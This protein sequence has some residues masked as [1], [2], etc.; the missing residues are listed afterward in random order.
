MNA[1]HFHV[2]VL[3]SLFSQG[4]DGALR[5]HE[6]TGLGSEDVER[7]AHTIQRRVLRHFVR[8]GL[9]DDG[10]AIDMLTWQ[11]AGGFSLNASVRVEGWDRAGRER[12]L[13]YCARPPFAL[14]RLDTE[15]APSP[16]TAH[17][18]APLHCVRYRLPRPTPDGRTVRVL[19]P[20]EFLAAI[21]RLIPPPHVHRQRNHGVLAPNAR[22]RPAVTA[23]PRQATRLAEMESDHP[24][25]LNTQADEAA[26]PAAAVSRSVAHHGQRLSSTSPTTPARPESS[27]SARPTTPSLW[28]RLL[29]R[30]YEVFPL[31]CPTCGGEL[32]ILAFL[33]E[34][35]P[36]HDILNHLGLPTRLPR[37]SPARGPPELKFDFDQT[38][39]F[40]PSEPEPSA[41]FHF[42]QSR[43]R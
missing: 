35:Q 40:D 12:L 3:D 43:A 8:R 28:A 29:A 16:A 41:E 17:E 6:A 11:A 39:A 36:I 37:P 15:F 38:P 27:A 2:V 13:R 26:S 31:L 32:R 42:D 14:E 30:I 33:T 5:F 1:L 10:V 34:P 18:H 24:P 9:L 4:D 23:W 7:L 19:S 22:L 21:A 25:T 20:L